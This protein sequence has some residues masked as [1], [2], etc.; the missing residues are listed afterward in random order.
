ME[1]IAV[2]VRRVEQRAPSFGISG[3]LETDLQRA[4]TLAKWLDAQ[5][6]FMGVRF[7]MDAIVGLIP[8]VGDTLTALAATYP[9]LVAQRHG[10]GRT[11]QSRMAFNVFIDWLPGLIPVVGDVIDV[12]YKANLKNLKLL[13][14]AAEKKL[15]REGRVA[16]G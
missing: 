16:G 7:G 11:V 14:K 6:S 10:L 9:I 15:A 13:E 12:A 1:T 5:F 4:R 8:V 3:D 2:D